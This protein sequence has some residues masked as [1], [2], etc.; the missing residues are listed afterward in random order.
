MV[1]LS[2]SGC[3]LSRYGIESNSRH[4]SASANA[5]QGSCEVHHLPDL[6]LLLVDADARTPFR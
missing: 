1:G 6:A 5:H 3:F 2:C 4:F